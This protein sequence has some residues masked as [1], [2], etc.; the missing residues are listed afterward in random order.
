[1][2]VFV[3]MLCDG[4]EVLE[5]QR[6]FVLWVVVATC[7]VVSDSTDGVG[8]RRDRGEERQ[9]PRS[10]RNCAVVVTVVTAVEMGIEGDYA[11][12]TGADRGEPGSV[13]KCTGTEAGNVIDEVIEDGV[14][15]LR[16]KG[17]SH[18]C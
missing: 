2:A 16:W 10:S 12:E 4:R 17:Y 18:I 3:H 6:N 13:D 7:R 11:E 5:E 1:M 9:Y 15:K 14:D 8:V